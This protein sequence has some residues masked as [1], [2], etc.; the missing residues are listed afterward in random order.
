MG[1]WVSSR[2][3]AL[4]RRARRRPSAGDKTYEG[5]DPIEERRA[6]R[7]QAALEAATALTFKDCTKQYLA[8]HSAGWR[9][10][11]HA[12]QWSSTLK[13]YAEPVIG[14]LSVHGIGTALVMKIIEPFW[15]KK[16]ETASRPD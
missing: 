3:L 10:A 11:K 13:T 4:P 9:N 12:A 2:S 1:L 6:Q 7:V 16:L 14:V 15:S 8:V 5:I